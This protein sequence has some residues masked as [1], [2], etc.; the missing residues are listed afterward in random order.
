MRPDE[1][2]RCESGCVMIGDKPLSEYLA[3][4][5]RGQLN[6]YDVPSHWWREE[7]DVYK[8]NGHGPSSSV[9]AYV[10]WKSY[11][12][13]PDFAVWSGAFILNA[14]Y[15]LDRYGNEYLSGGI[16][17]DVGMPFDLAVM[18]GY[19]TTHRYGPYKHYNE[20]RL[21]DIIEGLDVSL[22]VHLVVFGGDAS[23][24]QN[25]SG[26]LT[27]MNK[28]FLGGGIGASYTI[29]FNKNETLA[30]DW[31]DQV[32]FTHADLMHRMTNENE[33]ENCTECD[34]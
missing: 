22:S 1:T 26:T 15:T 9:P 20:S 7:V 28:G 2:L 10:D 27:Y 18:E 14:A 34:Y 33:M 30:W 32:G 21:R 29:W 8:L 6:Y 23:L 3:R 12:E 25:W 31:I 19:A 11:S 17:F 5:D 4:L 13:T 24:G 16:G